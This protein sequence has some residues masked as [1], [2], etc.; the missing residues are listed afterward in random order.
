MRRG[1]NLQRANLRTNKRRTGIKH[2]G[3][4]EFVAIEQVTDGTTGD[5]EECTTGDTIEETT[6]DHGLDILRHCARN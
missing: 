4:T 3:S 5:T 6:D 1:G 2:H